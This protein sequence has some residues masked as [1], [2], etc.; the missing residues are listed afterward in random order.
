GGA[1]GF[2]LSHVT[3]GYS[4]HNDTSPPLRDIVD[5]HG[6]DDNEER[7]VDLDPIDG[8][9]TVVRSAT[10]PDAMPTPILNFDGIPFPGVACNCAPPNMNGEVG[11]TQYVQVVREGYQVFD[12]TTGTSVL[13]PLSIASL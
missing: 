6:T 3:V 4:Y 13:G 2:Q 8:K 12:K 1:L 10:E 5:G 9:D 7:P 11:A